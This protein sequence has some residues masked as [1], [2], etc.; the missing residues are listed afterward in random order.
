MNTPVFIIIPD[1]T[2][3]AGRRP[4]LG[5]VPNLCCWCAYLPRILRSLNFSL[6]LM[7]K[8]SLIAFFSLERKSAGMMPKMSRDLFLSD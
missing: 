8:E 5:S 4:P 7:V 1:Y 2:G 6:S 3:A